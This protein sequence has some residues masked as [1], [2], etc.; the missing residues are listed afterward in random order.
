[1]PSWYRGPGSGSGAASVTTWV[2]DRGEVAG[3]EV[4]GTA[5]VVVETRGAGGT[6]PNSRKLILLQEDAAAEVVRWLVDVFQG[7]LGGP[8]ASLG[9]VAGPRAGYYQVPISYRMDENRCR[10]AVPGKLAVCAAGRPVPVSHPAGSAAPW[11]HGWIGTGR[12]VRVRIPEHGMS[13]DLAPA[14]AVR[15]EFRL[16][17]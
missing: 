4:G 12:Q 5:V 9:D 11:R 13:L 10:V 15:G 16:C 6:G 3:I 17:S 7:R 2:I 8:L 14:R 1:M